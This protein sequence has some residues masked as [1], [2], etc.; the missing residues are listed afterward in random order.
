MGEDDA[1]MAF[2]C[3]RCGLCCKHVGNFRFMQGFDRGDGTCV[4]LTDENLC[5]IYEDRPPVCNTEL[6]FERVYSRFMSREEYDRMNTESCEK[7][8][9]RGTD[10]KNN[11]G[12]QTL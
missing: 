3:D 7:I 4:H 8:K 10:A 1:I 2:N 11:P 9:Q 12:T 6:M 5:D